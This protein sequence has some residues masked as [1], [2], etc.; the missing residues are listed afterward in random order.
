M[1]RIRLAVRGN[2][3]ADPSL[4]TESDYLTA[5]KGR[6]HSLVVPAN[7]EVAS[8]TTGYKKRQHLG[9]FCSFRP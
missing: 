2:S 6:G 7:E 3:L 9:H 1:R 8:F 4:L 5:L